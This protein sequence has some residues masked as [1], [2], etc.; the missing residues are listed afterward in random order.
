[1]IKIMA[2][3]IAL[4]AVLCI[5]IDVHFTN[6][7]HILIR[8]INITSEFLV[9]LIKSLLVNQLICWINIGGPKPVVHYTNKKNSS[10]H[11]PD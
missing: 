8:F 6:N 1:M 9:I 11:Q 2:A 4:K 7:A 3:S 5:V 10:Y